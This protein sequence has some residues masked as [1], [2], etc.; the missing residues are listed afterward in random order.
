MVTGDDSLYLSLVLSDWVVDLP[1]IFWKRLSVFK[2]KERLR[3]ERECVSLNT[4]KHLQ[5]VHYGVQHILTQVLR[6]W[7]FFKKSYQV[8]GERERIL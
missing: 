2:G 3:E 5:L 8:V 1:A 6:M 7:V 4:L